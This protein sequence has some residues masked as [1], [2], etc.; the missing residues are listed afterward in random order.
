[1]DHWN[2]N[3]IFYILLELAHISVEW[4]VKSKYQTKNESAFWEGLIMKY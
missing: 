2:K 1:M 3:N 4:K